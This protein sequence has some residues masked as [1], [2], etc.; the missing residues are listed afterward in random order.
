MR[1]HVPGAP[2]HPTG[3]EVMSPA[4]KLAGEWEAR[5]DAA[6]RSQQVDPAAALHRYLSRIRTEEGLRHQ[7]HP[8]HRSESLRSGRGRH[9]DEFAAEHPLAASWLR[10]G[11]DSR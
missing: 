5:H 11:E 2:E 10:W 1:H 3:S 7:D 4:E 6:A 8:A 9:P